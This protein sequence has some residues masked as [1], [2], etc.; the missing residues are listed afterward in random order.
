MSAPNL[1]S[2]STITA[3]SSVVALTTG[4]VT[5]LQNAASSNKV[6][7]VSSLIVSNIDGSSAADLT[8]QISKAGGSATSIFST[9]S[10]PADSVLVALDKNTTIY[11]EENDTLTGTASANSDLVAFIS[12]EEIS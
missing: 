4:G 5:V 9:V 1:T 10:V 8:L 3:K 2:I 12:Y 11:L 6:F 7:K